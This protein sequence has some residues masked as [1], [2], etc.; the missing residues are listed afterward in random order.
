MC[1]PLLRLLT[2]VLSH[3][4]LLRLA[5]ADFDHIYTHAVHM[6]GPF[7]AAFVDYAPHDIV[8]KGVGVV[9]T[10]ESNGQTPPAALI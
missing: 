10:F 7:N 3:H 4:N 5:A 6:Y 1:A 9:G 8:D 2:N